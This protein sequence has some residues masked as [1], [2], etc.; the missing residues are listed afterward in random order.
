MNPLPATDRPADDKEPR[1]RKRRPRING[2]ARRQLAAELA[3]RHNEG[4][5]I[6]RNAL[7]HGLTWPFARKLLLEHG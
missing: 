4:V 5:S 7:D 1:T 6:Q 2:N 3:R